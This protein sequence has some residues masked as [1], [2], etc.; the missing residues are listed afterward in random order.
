[1]LKSL[2]LGRWAEL[3]P[4]GAMAEVDRV[5]G[6]EEGQSQMS[7]YFG[8]VSQWANRDPEA[9]WNWYEKKRDDGQTS[10]QGFGFGHLFLDGRKEPSLRS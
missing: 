2:L 8:V 4:K 1:M 6:T 5:L 10:G 7:L 3:D 9:A